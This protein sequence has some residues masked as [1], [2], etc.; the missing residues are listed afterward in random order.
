MSPS[1]SWF[2]KVRWKILKRLFFVASLD[3]LLN[4]RLV[5]WN[6]LMLMWHHQDG[7]FLGIYAHTI[8]VF[9]RGQVPVDFTNNLQDHPAHTEAITLPLSQ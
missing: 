7:Y 3:M 9:N 8:F 5:N 1:D 6:A 4:E 2:L